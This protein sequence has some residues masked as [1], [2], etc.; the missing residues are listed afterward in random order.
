MM[1]PAEM[2][3]MANPAA[4]ARVRPA[5]SA[6]FIPESVVSSSNEIKYAPINNVKPHH[7]A[8]WGFFHH[9]HLNFDPRGGA[10]VSRKSSCK[11]CFGQLWGRNKLLKEVVM[12]MP[13]PT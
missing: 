10:F 13:I 7:R 6:A 4:I 5:T 1:A 3:R 9:L 2:M 11:E 12:I 8:M